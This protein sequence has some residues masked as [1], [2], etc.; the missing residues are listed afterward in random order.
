MDPSLVLKNYFRAQEHRKIEGQASISVLQMPKHGELRNEGAGYFAYYPEKGYIGNDRAT[1]L[2]ET[3]GKKIKMEYF[4]RVMQTV[5]SAEDEPAIYEQG[6]CPL[7]AR[8]WKISAPI[9][10]DGNNISLAFVHAL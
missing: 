2:V 6:Y 5:P 3:G 10:A 8:V 9:N 7:K 1:L 4:R